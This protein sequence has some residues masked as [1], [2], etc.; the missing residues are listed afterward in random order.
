MYSRRQKRK[1]WLVREITAIFREILQYQFSRKFNLYLTFFHSVMWV[2]VTRHEVWI[3]N[4]IYSTLTW[5]TANN[6]DSLTEL[7]ILWVAVS[8]S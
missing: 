7:H 2:S 3:G 1:I 4:R 5:A 8:T 6:Y